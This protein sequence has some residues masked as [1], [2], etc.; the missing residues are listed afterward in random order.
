MSGSHNAY[1]EV[2]GPST[3]ISGVPNIG[4]VTLRKTKDS[5]Y[6]AY[7]RGSLMISLARF[8]SI[9]LETCRN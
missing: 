4:K 8:E 6:P 5:R 2:D 1:N 3:A 7:P 9:G